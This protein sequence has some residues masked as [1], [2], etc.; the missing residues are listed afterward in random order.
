VEVTAY[1]TSYFIQ[2]LYREQLQV[3]T[4]AVGNCRPAG[5][6]LIPQ[7][8]GII[9]WANLDGSPCNTNSSGT[10]VQGA[11]TMHIY[12][13]GIYVN[14]S[15]N[16]NI[17][18]ENGAE[19]TIEGP[20][21]LVGSPDTSISTDPNAN[22]CLGNTT[23]PAPTQ[24]TDMNPLSEWDRPDCG[25]ARSAPGGGT[26]TLQPGNYAGQT[27]G[28]NASDNYTLNPGI[29]CLKGFS[30]NGSARLYGD[31]VVFYFPEGND[32]IS[33][34]GGDIFLRS[35]TTGLDGTCEDTLGT[36]QWAGLLIWS[37]VTAPLGGD[38]D[39]NDIIQ[40]NGGDGNEWHGMI[41][42][43]GNSCDLQGN[44]EKKFFGV[45]ACWQVNS[46]GT[47]DTE[48]YYEKPEFLYTPP[49]VEIAQ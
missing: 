22:P 20:C 43:P 16:C 33:G 21:Q 30:I 29:Y 26:Q 42:A 14:S 15:G 44:G 13:A 49:F 48:I 2:L 12:N 41:Y 4:S 40:I 7:N 8:A 36:C 46:Q 3:T 27:W 39:I 17:R 6:G 28:L 31:G 37:D 32:G 23:S 19:F 10:Q 35:P 5:G 24:L 38:G 1:K 45:L 34:N 9:S 25:V 11:G 47:A 18:N